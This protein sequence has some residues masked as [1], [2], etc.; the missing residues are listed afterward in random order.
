MISFPLENFET[1][2]TWQGFSQLAVP[3]IYIASNV[4]IERAGL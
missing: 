4:R 2:A 3:L 1:G